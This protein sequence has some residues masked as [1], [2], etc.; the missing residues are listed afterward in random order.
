MSEITIKCKQKFKICLWK[1]K[2][3]LFFLLLSRNKENFKNIIMDKK[4][5]KEKIKNIVTTKGRWFKLVYYIIH[6]QINKE[7][8]F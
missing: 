5:E 6:I 8:I 2:K 1:K 3:F 7:N 4:Q